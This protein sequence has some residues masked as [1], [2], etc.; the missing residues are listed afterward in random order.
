MLANPDPDNVV[1]IDAAKKGRVPYAPGSQ[2]TYADLYGS[3]RVEPFEFS[4]QK[5]EP[6]S[7]EKNASNRLVWFTESCLVNYL[8]MLRRRRLLKSTAKSQ[9]WCQ[10]CKCGLTDSGDRRLL[11][12]S[13]SLQGPFSI[14]SETDCATSTGAGT[15][16][17]EQSSKDD[18]CKR[19]HN[20]FREWRH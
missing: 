15:F 17:Q 12:S 1:N 2:V 8:K 13:S 10:G 11:A 14:A 16:D 6:I 3:V 9:N 18:D 5:Q 4:P 20:G 7:Q 19:L